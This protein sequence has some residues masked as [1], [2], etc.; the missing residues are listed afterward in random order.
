MRAVSV[1][2]TSPGRSALVFTAS[3]HI[4]YHQVEEMIRIPFPTEGELAKAVAQVRAAAEESARG[5]SS[6]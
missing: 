5:E 4:I 3:G 1:F 2:W 6:C